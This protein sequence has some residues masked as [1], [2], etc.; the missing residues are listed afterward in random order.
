MKKL[1]GKEPLSR[2]AAGLAS[3]DLLTFRKRR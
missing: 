2:T 1:F 3:C